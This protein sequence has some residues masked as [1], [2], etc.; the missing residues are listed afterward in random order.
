MH[1]PRTPSQLA[2]DEGA[3]GGEVHALVAEGRGGEEAI[4][5]GADLLARAQAR[6][7]PN[8]NPNP[9]P[10]SNSN[11][12]PTPT[13]TPNQATWGAIP[14]KPLSLP[15]C[16]HP[17]TADDTY[18]MLGANGVRKPVLWVMDSGL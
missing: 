15:R 5:R 9:N 2:H 12:T 1:R 14:I 17:R 8:P 11:P 4:K 18:G 13:P 16:M 7:D 6:Y 10:N 3:A